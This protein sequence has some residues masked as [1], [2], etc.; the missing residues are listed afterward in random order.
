[1]ESTT[2]SFEDI[3]RRAKDNAGIFDILEGTRG[4]DALT[5]SDA[6]E[7]VT[8]GNGDDSLLG[9]GGIDILL[10]GRGDDLMNTGAGLGVH[11]GGRGADTFQIGDDILSNGVIDTVIAFGFDPTRGDV[12]DLGDTIT[13]V[14]R[15]TLAGTDT[16]TLSLSE[17]A[18]LGELAEALDGVVVRG[19]RDLRALQKLLDGAAEDGTVADATTVEVANGDRIIV[20]GVDVETL[21]AVL[22]ATVNPPAA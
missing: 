11:V 2:V 3:A 6:D 5:G 22:D 15:A 12:L 19:E 18:D 4:D 16:T 9:E 10:G 1:M 13:E 14:V 7:I 21:V 20:T 17:G 8:G